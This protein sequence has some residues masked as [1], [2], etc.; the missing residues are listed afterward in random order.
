[1]LSCF[2]AFSKCKKNNQQEN[3]ILQGVSVSALIYDEI[4]FCTSQY[5]PNQL[6]K[7]KFE[8]NNF[9]KISKIIGAPVQIYCQQSYNFWILWDSAYE[10]IT[11]QGSLIK[12]EHFTSPSSQNPYQIREYVLNN[13]ILQS[14]KIINS[15]QPNALPIEY[16]YEING[17]VIYENR[18]GSLHRT[19]TMDN[20]N[21]SKV[22][23][24]FRNPFSNITT[25]KSEI[26]FE[27]YDNKNNYLKGKYFITG[28]FYK[29]FSKNNY[30][31]VTT[32]QYSFTNNEFVLNSESSVEVPLKYDASDVADIFEVGCK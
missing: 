9:A 15:S 12:S 28:A 3:C 31:K 32:K 26:Y 23:T 20:G 25:G 13:D 30:T 1:M 21:L 24:V 11:Y 16:N 22:E 2:F 27:N 18:N 8:Y 17:N 19:F 29:S 5:D 10:K 6:L 4:Q 14:S 7:L